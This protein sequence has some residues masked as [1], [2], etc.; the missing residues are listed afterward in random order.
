MRSLILLALALSG[1]AAPRVIT[2]ITMSGDHAKLIYNGASHGL[3]EC[4]VEGDGTLAQCEV[5]PVTFL[6]KGE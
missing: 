2:G 4:Q 1:C 3:I 6:K 5:L